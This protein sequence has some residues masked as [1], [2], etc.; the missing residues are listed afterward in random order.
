ME[1][2]ADFRDDDEDDD[3]SDASTERS[4]RDLSEAANLAARVDL[5]LSAR[6]RRTPSSDVSARR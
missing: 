3:D 4:G 6:E 5:D 1:I 2:Q